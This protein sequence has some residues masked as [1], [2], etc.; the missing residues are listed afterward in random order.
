MLIMKNRILLVVEHALTL[1][2]LQT[3]FTN[4]PD[5]EIIGEATTRTEIQHTCQTNLP[6]LVLIDVPTSIG[7]MQEIADLILVNSPKTKLLVLTDDENTRFLEDVINTG[8][9]GYLLKK[10]VPEKLIGAISSAIDG[11]LIFRQ[12]AMNRYHQ[13]IDKGIKAENVLSLRE[14]EIL[15]LIAEGCTNEQIS[16]KLYITVG[17]VKNHLVHIYQKLDLHSRAEAVTWAWKQG[18]GS[19]E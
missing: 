9:S 4:A 15:Q 14:Q 5:V 18:F 13:N 2:G 19:E 10:D 3:I 7:T 17:T 8:I 11:D 16:Q 6:D 1:T 12:E